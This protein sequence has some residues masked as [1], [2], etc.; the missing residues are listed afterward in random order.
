MK[1]IHK[2]ELDFIS[3]DFKDE[4]EEKS[5]FQDGIIVRFDKKGNVIGLDITDSSSFFANQWLTMREACD[6]L[7]ISESTMRRRIKEGKIKHQ[8][9]MG[10]DYRFNKSDLLKLG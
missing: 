9:P 3:I 6:L 2:P 4:V 5:V 7:G 1:I 8:K 10:K